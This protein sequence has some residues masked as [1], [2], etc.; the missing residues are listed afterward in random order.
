MGATE[1]RRRDG[2]AHEVADRWAAE[3]K[4]ELQE[5]MEQKVENTSNQQQLNA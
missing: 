2:C 4:L 5:K 3:M 1:R